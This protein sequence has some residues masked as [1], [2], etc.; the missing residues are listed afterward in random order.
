MTKKNTILDVIARKAGI[1]LDQMVDTSFKTLFLAGVTPKMYED[2]FNDMK[3]GEIRDAKNYIE[4]GDSE[5]LPESLLP[6]SIFPFSDFLGE[7]DREPLRAFPLRDAEKKTLLL[8]I[9]LRGIKKPP[10]WREVEVPADFNFLQLSKIIQILM[11]W[12]GGHL[13]LFEESPYGRGFS[14]GMSKNTR[15]EFEVDDCTNEADET[16]LTA[17]FKKEGDKI[18]YVYDFGDEWFHDITL[19]KII[20]SP[21]S[22][23]VCVKWKSDNPAEDCGGIDSY[24]ELRDIYAHA[25]ELSKAQWNDVLDNGWWDTRRE[26]MDYMKNL[27]FDLDEVNDVMKKNLNLVRG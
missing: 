27:A 10:L 4:S 22:Y 2:Y 6:Q 25:G 21:S 17:I 16:P 24:E 15:P 9:Q 26:F 12:D 8:R 14:I 19:K 23:P 1:D 3:R 20:D 18:C 11:G 13:W 5:D 7:T